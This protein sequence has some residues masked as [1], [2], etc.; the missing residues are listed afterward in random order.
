MTLWP[1]SSSV[2]EADRDGAT[3]VREFDYERLNRQMR[4]VYDVMRDGEW[5]SLRGLSNATGCPEAS[6]SARLRDFRKERFGGLTLERERLDGGLWR[7]R[8]VTK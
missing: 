2:M 8:L 5:H 6:V 4:L 3:F 7:Y 1:L